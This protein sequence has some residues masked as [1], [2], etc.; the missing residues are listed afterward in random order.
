M[1]TAAV[2]SLTIRRAEPRDAA[3]FA[4]LFCDSAMLP[5]TQIPPYSGATY[6]DKR[7]GEY[8]DAASLPLVAFAGEALVGVLLL[9]AFPNHVR[10]KHA[11][12]LDLLAVRPD[13]RR[14]GV[15]RAL[16]N[17][18]VRAADEGL[19]LRRI[20][21]NVP[22]RSSHAGNTATPLEQFYASF[23]FELEGV[24]RFDLAQAGGYADSATLARVNPAT[25]PAPP[26]PAL[27]AAKRPRRSVPAKVVIRPAT[28][29]DA[30]G[31]ARVFAD[32][33]AA[34]GTLQHPYTTAELWRTRLA[35]GGPGNRQAMFVALVN[36]RVVGN[37]GVHP[38][39]DNPR[40]RHVCGI[41]IAI[42]SRH[43]GL[44]IGRALMNYTL[45][46]A[47]RWANYSRIEL[48]VHADNA[49]A[50]QLYE[51]LGFIHEG[52]HRDFSFRDGGYVDALF[53]ARLTA[54]LLAVA[55]PGA[56]A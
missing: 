34:L 47:E 56:T 24:K 15:G 30:E 25:M 23:G 46:F 1:T 28:E 55:R 2:P 22:R 8:A 3:L 11:G 39:S 49:R 48:T 13:Q 53:M 10:R 12:V 26:S 38:V 19:Q 6:W 51:S 14:R 20:E 44:G 36:G 17:A 42:S 52:R 18:A 50:V 29:D 54:A 4:A 43:Q 40:L 32:R 16:L 21:V 45:D 5:F 41:G 37:A 7:L 33:S 27:P 35:A 9:R 31:F